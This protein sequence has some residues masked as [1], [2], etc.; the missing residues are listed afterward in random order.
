M[1]AHFPNI[2]DPR[3]EKKLWSASDP[4]FV[5]IGHSVSCDCFDNRITSEVGSHVL[6]LSGGAPCIIWLIWVIVWLKYLWNVCSVTYSLWVVLRV[7]VWDILLLR[8][9][10]QKMWNEAAI[11]LYDTAGCQNDAANPHFEGSQDTWM[12]GFLH[13]WLR[14]LWVTYFIVFWPEWSLSVGDGFTV[15]ICCYNSVSSSIMS[16]ES[17]LMSLGF[18]SVTCKLTRSMFWVATFRCWLSLYLNLYCLSIIF[19]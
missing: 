10:L 7:V 2:S 5:K 6:S 18:A 11:Y 16:S 3:Q 12:H 17:T 15:L 19:T 13:V 1:S 14:V 8:A 4:I 9:Y